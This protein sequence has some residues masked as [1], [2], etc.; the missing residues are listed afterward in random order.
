MAFLC[1]ASLCERIVIL[2]F[3]LY[4]IV[5]EGKRC[6][7]TLHPLAESFRRQVVDPILSYFFFHTFSK[8][9]HVFIICIRIYIHP[10]ADNATRGGIV[11]R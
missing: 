6:S 5:P 4:I 3:V 1:D 8:L 10:Y 7:L 2:C 9:S 11:I